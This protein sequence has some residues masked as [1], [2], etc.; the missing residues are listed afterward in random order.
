MKKATFAGGCFWCTEAVFK[1]LKGVELVE[2]GYTG[3]NMD[4]PDYYRVSEGKTGH[5]EAVQITFDPKTISYN[6]LLEVF[7]A[8]HD[9]TTLNSQ[10]NDI[11][12]QYRSVIFYHDEGQKILAEESRKKH[13]KKLKSKIVTEIK[14][15]EKFYKAEE[16]HQDYYDQNQ[17]YPY[18]TFVIAPKI[19][20]LIEKFGKNVKEEYMSKL[21]F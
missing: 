7:W 8:T 16:Y 3:G 19:K 2:S 1:R 18:C 5:A 6:T 12:T 20:K 17:N 14:P 15:F 13:Q 9:P 11:G 21:D 10:G 4:N